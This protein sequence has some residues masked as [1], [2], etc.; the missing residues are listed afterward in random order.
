M[1]EPDSGSWHD[2]FITYDAKYQKYIAWDETQTYDI[3]SFD[4]WDEAKIAL[5]E[6]AKTL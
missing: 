1:S 5:D 6:Y 2:K 3:G 4:T